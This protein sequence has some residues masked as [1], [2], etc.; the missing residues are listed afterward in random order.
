M[1]VYACLWYMVSLYVHACIN[2]SVVTDVFRYMYIIQIV[3][4]LLTLR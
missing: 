2:A 1:Y 4:S 3:G